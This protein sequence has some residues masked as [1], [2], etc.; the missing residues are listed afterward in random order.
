MKKYF[1]YLTVFVVFLFLGAICY[2]IYDSTGLETIKEKIVKKEKTRNNYASYNGFLSINNNYLVNEKDEKIILKGVSSHG[3]QWYKDLITNEN[4]KILKDE[5]KTNVFR[6][7]MYTKENGFIDNNSLK[8][9][10]KRIIDMLIELDMYAIVDW[11]ILSDSNPLIYKEESI[12]FFDDISSLYKDKPNV[13]YEICN[14]P[15][16]NTSFDDISKYSNEVINKIRSNSPKSLIIVGTPNYSL[17]IDKVKP[18]EF[19]NVLYTLHFYADSHKDE[20]RDKFDIAINKNIPVFVSEFSV[21]DYSC[22][23]NIN[24]DETYKWIKKLKNKN[25]GLVAWALSNKNETCSIL[26]EGTNQLKEE[27]LTDTGKFLKE[28]LTNY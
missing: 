12:K 18:L 13:I 14:E 19:T 22:Q 7:A 5:W 24:K 11:H 21:S 1:K 16:G 23:G 15:N 6:I 4:L 17:D 3:I 2:K 9:D 28:V 20:V 27:N 26:K 8:E 25:I 10:V